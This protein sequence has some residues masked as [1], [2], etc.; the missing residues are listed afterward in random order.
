MFVVF[1][2]PPGAGKG[3]QSKRLLAHLGIPHV[4]T[5]DMLRQACAEGTEVGLAAK[6]YVDAG[7]LVPDALIEEMVQQRLSLPDCANGCL[8][9]GFPRTLHQ[10][11]MLD[12]ILEQRGTPLDVALE[13]RVEEAEL[14]R[15]LAGR[16]TQEK[17]SDDKPEIIRQ[18]LKKFY[19]SNQRLLDFYRRKGLLRTMDG[20][21]TA[22][23]VFERIKQALPGN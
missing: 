21:G 2:G 8:F 16:A 6:E 5:G 11:E 12:R 9:D 20:L 15:R 7:E 14:I 19:E 1:I 3:V 10:A 23:E 4:S 18:R 13:L 22:D 17:R